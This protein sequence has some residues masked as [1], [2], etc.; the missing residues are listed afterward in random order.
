MGFLSR[1]LRVSFVQ[2]PSQLPMQP[3]ARLRVAEAQLRHAVSSRAPPDV[4][5]FP[6]CFLCGGYPAGLAEAPSIGAAA[7]AQAHVER[8]AED[9]V[10]GESL[11]GITA[12][13][14]KY[15]VHVVVG[16][17]ERDGTNNC[18]YNSAALI[19]RD[20]RRLTTYRKLHTGSWESESMFRCGEKLPAV[21]EL[22]ARRGVVRVAL[23]ICYDMYFPEVARTVRG[24]GAEVLL[25]PWHQED[26]PDTVFA[27]S[28]ARAM[29][30]RGLAIASA[31]WAHLPGGGCVA[32]GGDARVV[33]RWGPEGGEESAKRVS[34]SIGAPPGAGDVDAFST[35][36]GA[37]PAGDTSDEIYVLGPV[38]IPMGIELCP[39]EVELCNWNPENDL[40]PLLS[41]AGVAR[42]TGVGGEGGSET[43]TIGDS[44]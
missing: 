11:R 35:P 2:P 14:E 22:P 17:V 38:E 12:L 4:L 39:R 27:F 36:I 37:P 13:A 24:M 34:T 18:Y 29:E 9:A 32:V 15:Q 26:F 6:E 40:N 1:S 44:S 7:A 25:V 30:N 16:F 21:V 19:D 41:R 5:L 43:G 33:R 8:W 42:R 28:V 3:P 10:E 31:N 20:G 23:A